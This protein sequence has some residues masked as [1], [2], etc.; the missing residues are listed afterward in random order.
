METLRAQIVDHIAQRD[1]ADPA[2]EL[3]Q[4]AGA[5]DVEAALSG[6]PVAPAVFVVRMGYRTSDNGRTETISERIMLLLAVRNVRTAA[7]SDSSDEA[8]RLSDKVAQ[9]LADL[10]P[11]VPERFVSL[12]RK[13]GNAV[14]F[15]QQVLVW[16]DTYELIHVRRCRN[17]ERA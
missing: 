15:D 16:G 7:G 13:A 12:K 5:A 1:A 9:W 3:R 17:C 8:E 10:K 4:V 11:S 6:A 2:R 14:K